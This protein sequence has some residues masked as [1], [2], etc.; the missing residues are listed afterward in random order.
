MLVM[1]HLRKNMAST[2]TITTTMI[3][4]T[5]TIAPA[6]IPVFDPDPCSPGSSG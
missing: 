6:T 2:A 4:R 1:T 3:R 5:T